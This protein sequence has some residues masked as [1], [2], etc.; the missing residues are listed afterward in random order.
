MVRLMPA[1]DPDGELIRRSLSDTR[2]FA[3]IFDRHF[4]VVFRY[5]AR[6]VGPDDASDLTSEVF[7]EAL[8]TRDRFDCTAT[9][10]APWLF[11]IASNLLR[12][13]ARSRR[14]LFNALARAS[15]QPS[16]WFDPDVASR[17][18]AEGETN[19]LKRALES[20]RTVDRD[21][22]LLWALAELPYADIATA[23]SIQVGTVKSRLSRSRKQIRREIEATRLTKSGLRR[24]LEKPHE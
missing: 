8:R 2:H 23:L 6:R 18:D 12:Q 20:L 21:I 10:A 17:I 3:V 4:D 16:V 15:A 14:R 22:F 13:H 24:T 5:L 7:S 11:G 19:V 9:S 1:I